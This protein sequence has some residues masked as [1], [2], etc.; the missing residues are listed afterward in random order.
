[1]SKFGKKSMKLKTVTKNVFLQKF[2]LLQNEFGKFTLK[3]KKN[4]CFD[5]INL[6]NN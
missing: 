1:M 6:K 2:S 4:N 3:N 5:F